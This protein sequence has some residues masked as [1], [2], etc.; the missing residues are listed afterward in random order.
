M[1]V[2]LKN[3]DFTAAPKLCSGCHED[4]HANQFASR[5]EATDCSSCHD[6]VRWKPSQFD[7]NTRTRYPLDGA[8]KDVPCLDCHKL[9]QEV[10]GKTVV[11]Y[12][13]TP[14]KCEDCH[15]VK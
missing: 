4:V 9:T 5:P 8:H 6:A 1:E 14:T 13:P 2:T 12:K 11:Y 10:A 15:G 3:V 7:H